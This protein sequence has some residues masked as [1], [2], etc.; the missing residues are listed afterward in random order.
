MWATRGYYELLN[1]KCNWFVTF[2]YDNEHLPENHS[3]DKKEFQKFLKR[4]KFHYGS[5]KQNPIRQIYCGEYGDKNSRPHYHAILFNINLS[6]LEETRATDQGYLCYSSK[7][8][9]AIWKNGLVEISEATP[10]L[11]AYLFKYVLKK[12]S[13]LEKKAPLTITTPDGLTYDVAHEFIEASR[14]PGIGAHLRES[15]SI[16][17]GFLSLDGSIR[18]LPKYFLEYIKNTDPRWYEE[19]KNQ[20]YDYASSL[21]Q[22]PQTEKDRRDAYYKEKQRL[23]KR[24]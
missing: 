21:P 8:L 1:W 24:D 17:K 12:K 14:N 19:L 9:Q 23:K 11:V 16:R 4:L 10:A 13:R 18:A 15:P 22:V 5:S 2:T 3:L 20:R 7:E 6:D